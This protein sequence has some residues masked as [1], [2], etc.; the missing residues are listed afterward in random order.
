MVPKEGEAEAQSY[1][2]F[3]EVIVKIE[4]KT[5]QDGKRTG[6]IVIFHF[7]TLI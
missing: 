2:L 1:T 7:K 6:H 4:E 3:P 5:G